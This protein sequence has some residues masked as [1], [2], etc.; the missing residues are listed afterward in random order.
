MLFNHVDVTLPRL[1]RETID[2]I[3]F[4][5]VPDGDELL[6]LV[7]ITSITS[8]K[9]KEFFAEWRKKIGIEKADRITKQ[10]TSRGTDMHTLTENY[11]LNIPELPK[12]QPLEFIFSKLDIKL[13]NNQLSSCSCCMLNTYD[14]SNLHSK[15]FS[16]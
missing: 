12:V 4:Y 1:Q 14:V 3:R 15:D 9:N 13:T 2:G 10:A 7:S 5:K 8:H 16:R 11:L 6:K